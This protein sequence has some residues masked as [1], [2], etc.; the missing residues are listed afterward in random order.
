[1]I[2]LDAYSSDAIPVHLITREALQLY[3]DKL[4]PDGVL[5]FHL[6]NRHLDLAT[7]V[8]NLALDAGLVSRIEGDV[9]LDPDEASRAKMVSQWA[10]LARTEEDLDALADDP[11]WVVPPIRRNTSVWTD[12]FNNLLSVLR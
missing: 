1:L 12:D 8:G 3:L 11:R 9:D 10:V 2:I 4:A 6:T 7:V 5:V